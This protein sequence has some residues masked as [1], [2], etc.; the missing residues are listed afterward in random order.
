M[1]KIFTK[2]E[3]LLII[4]SEDKKSLKHDIYISYSK[5]PS[6]PPFLFGLEGVLINEQT[7]SYLI[8]N[9]NE[10]KVYIRSSEYKRYYGRKK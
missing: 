3:K 6:L 7:Y 10:G 2:L 9:L 4:T 1:R 8:K 5:D